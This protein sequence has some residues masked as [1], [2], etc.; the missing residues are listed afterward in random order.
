MQLLTTMLLFDYR[1]ARAMASKDDMGDREQVNRQVDPIEGKLDQLGTKADLVTIVSDIE[2]MFADLMG[3][4]NDAAQSHGAQL[5]RIERTLREMN[6]KMDVRN[7][8]EE[9]S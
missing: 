3:C 4:F 8:R 2:T 1:A 9:P 5:N 7:P 6:E